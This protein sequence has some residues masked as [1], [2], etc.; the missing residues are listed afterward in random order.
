MVS[1]TLQEAP[2]QELHPEYLNTPRLVADSSGT[3]VW[4]WD[5]Q[6]PFGNNPADENPSGLGAFELPLRLPGQYFD[7]E[8]GL[9]QNYFRDYDPSL[10]IYKESDPIGL[11]GGLNT[12]GYAMASPVQYADATGLDVWMCFRRLDRRLP[13][14]HTYLWDDTKNRCCGRV[15]GTDPL[16]DCREKGPPTDFCVRVAGSG[17]KESEI[18]KCCEVR[19]KSGTYVPYYNDCVN[20]AEDCVTQSNLKIPPGPK[21]G[22]RR[23]TCTSCYRQDPPTSP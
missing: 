15:P 4:R 19:G 23:G 21:G 9:H 2:A 11:R 22:A 13:G 17:G 12:Y 1:P 7:K 5:Q 14:N 20:T 3:T 18:L 10:A 16:V 6:E 8:T